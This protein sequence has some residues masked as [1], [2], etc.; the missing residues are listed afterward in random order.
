M[1]DSIKKTNET[2]Y[3]DLR[4]TVMDYIIVET[5]IISVGLAISVIKALQL[6]VSEI[7]EDLGVMFDTQS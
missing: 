7:A 6:I 1:I 5:I 2:G 4:R 3:R